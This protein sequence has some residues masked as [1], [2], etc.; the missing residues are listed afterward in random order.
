MAE[1][2]LDIII[3]GSVATWNMVDQGDVNGT[4]IGV[5][6]FRCYLTPIQKLACGREYRELLGPSPAMATSQDDNLAFAL[7]QLKHRVI[8]GPPFWQSSL[9]TTGYAGDLPD[10]VVLMHIL[11]ASISAEI[12]YKEQLKK[13]REE[14]ITRAENIAE[15]IKAKQDTAEEE[16]EVDEP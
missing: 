6:K 5:F 15:K 10:E 9:Q 11:D 3:D 16:L 4:Y 12:K 1:K 14:A 7:T 8:S 2:E 13:K